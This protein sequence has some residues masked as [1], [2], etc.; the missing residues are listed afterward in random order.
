MNSFFLLVEIFS[1]LFAIYLFL[2][3]K[4][5]AIIYLPV[6]VFC[7]VIIEARFSASIYYGTVSLLILSCIVRN[8]NFYRNNIFAILLF[9][10]F[11]FLLPRSSDLVFIRPYVFSVLWFFICLPLISAIY[12]KYS[13]EIIFQ[14]LSRSTLII[15]ILF[16]ANVVVSSAK[17]YSPHEMYGITKGVLYGN[18]Y[19]AGFNILAGAIFINVLKLLDQKKLIHLGIV[20]I[21]FVF[22]LLSLRRSVMLMSLL[23]AGIAFLTLL[24]QKKAKMFIVNGSILVLLGYFIYANTGFMDQFKERYELRKLDER[25]LA[26]EKR[27]IEYEL[28]YKDMFVYNDYSPWFGYEPFNSWG[29]Y[30][31]G[32]LAD[33]SLHGDLT[34]IAH[35]SGI[36]GLLLYLL[37]VFTVFHQ[38]FRASETTADKLILFF[39]A[40]A[41][42][43]F[44]VTGRYTDTG[45]MLMLFLVA[46]L[47]LAK[48]EEEEEEDPLSELEFSG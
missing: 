3:K 24:T 47:P 11:L 1:Y 48:S 16:V 5:L 44:T 23:G 27:F 12:Q 19:A 45:S 41:F 40:V 43:T 15:L 22:I 21:S 46:M 32:V 10:Y 4:D 29:N 7:Q 35:S 18:I 14:E 13:K 28:I 39:C 30:G 25:E 9:L 17:G 38:A 26:E 6:L 8:G 37:M 42:A 33:R 36:I 20:I 31:K 34:S 2:K